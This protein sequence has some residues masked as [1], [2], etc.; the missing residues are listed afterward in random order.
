[1]NNIVEVSNVE[2]SNIEIN[3]A[4]KNLRIVEGI[5]DLDV[6]RALAGVAQ[7]F[8][9]A[10]IISRI[11][12]S[13]EYI[14]QVPLRYNDALDAGKLFMNQ[15]SKNGVMWPTLMEKLENGK[16]QFV[17]NLPI[18]EE[19]RMAGNPIQ[20]IALAYQNLYMQNQIAQIADVVAETYRVVERIEHG[21]MDDRIALLDTGREQITFALLQNDED[22]KKQG[23]MMGRNNLI[24]AKNQIGKTLKRRVEEFESL[25]ENKNM[26]FFMEVFHPGYLARRD[27]EVEEIQNY[28]EMYLNATN[29]LAA[30][31]A[32]SG[33]IEAAKQVYISSEEFMKGINFENIKTIELSHKKEELKDMFFNRSL[34]Y[35][36]VDE[37][38]CMEE[39][40]PYDTV[41]IE[42]TGEKLLEVLK[43]GRKEEISKTETKSR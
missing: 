6:Q 12:V 5:D 35:I 2:E 17:D 27:E 11:D 40:E 39:A 1:M 26:R 19:R 14:V 42:V 31:Y 13:K 15:N 24:L 18:K 38:L 23:I 7:H 21:Q 25:P 30:S 8:S 29:M 20:D 34:E 37:E 16:K 33:E 36:E 22:E 32:Y 4:G 10:D 28:Y 43:D 3:N 9:V 41:S